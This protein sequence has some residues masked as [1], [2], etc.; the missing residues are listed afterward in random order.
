M[1][2]LV[3]FEHE[4]L[5]GIVER[6]PALVPSKANGILDEVLRALV[7]FLVVPGPSPLKRE[8]GLPV[9][10]RKDFLLG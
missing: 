5:V 2:G 10:T 3:V 9:T 7:P 8:I 4:F 1:R 6:P